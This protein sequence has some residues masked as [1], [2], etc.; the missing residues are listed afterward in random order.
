MKNARTAF[1][2]VET[3]FPLFDLSNGDNALLQFLLF[4]FFFFLAKIKRRKMEIL[5]LSNNK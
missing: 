5:N 1:T 2:T 4:L 3:R